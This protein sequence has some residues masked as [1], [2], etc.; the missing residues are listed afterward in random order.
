VAENT[1]CQTF[2]SLVAFGTASQVS[3]DSPVSFA[4]CMQALSTVLSNAFKY[5][6]PVRHPTARTLP[7]VLHVSLRAFKAD[8]ESCNSAPGPHCFGADW[9]QLPRSTSSA[10]QE[11]AEYWAENRSKAALKHAPVE[12]IPSRQAGVIVISVSD[13]GPGCSEAELS[14][15]VEPFQDLRMGF[16]G[17]NRSGLGL[18]LMRRLLRSQ[19]GDLVAESTGPGLGSTFSL[20]I[21]A[22]WHAQALREHEFMPISAP[23][24]ETPLVSLVSTVR[25]WDMM[26]TGVHLAGIRTRIPEVATALTSRRGSVL[27]TSSSSESCFGVGAAVDMV[28]VVSHPIQSVSWELLDES[29]RAEQEAAPEMTVEPK[30]SCLPNGSA[31]RPSAVEACNTLEETA[32]SRKTKQSNWQGNHNPRCSST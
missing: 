2:A 26:R 19:G 12:E 24:H 25:S 20:V 22:T 1:T 23:A 18:W 7:A 3:I 16:S 21:P 17:R 28:Q 15:I 8:T 4:T 11:M 31:P 30:L 27:T 13:F 5:S 10:V 9:N 14:S 29:A 32:Q 6:S